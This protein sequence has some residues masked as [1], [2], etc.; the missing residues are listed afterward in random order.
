MPKT[1]CDIE[2]RMGPLTKAERRAAEIGFEAGELS[3]LRK[4]K[5]LDARPLGERSRM[6]WLF[7]A[8]RVGLDESD[9]DQESAYVMAWRLGREVAL[10]MA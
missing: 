10:E 3:A 4:S 8:N 1:F 9:E 6:S 2:D 7:L 5:V